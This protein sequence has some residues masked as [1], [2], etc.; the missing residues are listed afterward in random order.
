MLSILHVLGKLH[1]VDT[2]ALSTDVL[3]PGFRFLLD[4][5]LVLLEFFGEALLGGLLHLHIVH[6][7][8]EEAKSELDWLPLVGMDAGLL[9][10]H[11]E[12]E[13]LSDVLLPLL[14]EG[15]LS[16]HQR[17]KANVHALTVV[18]IALGQII[19]VFAHN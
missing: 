7:L 9:S 14:V 12:S 1:E 18:F 2:T 19:L 11:R 3:G 17:L 15:H 4:E 10:L 8:F 13:R 6:K 5:L 16:R